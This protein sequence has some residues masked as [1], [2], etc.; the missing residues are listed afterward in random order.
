MNKIILIWAIFILAV[1]LDCG[2]TFYGV[3]FGQGMEWN[4]LAA[5]FLH[6]EL[7][8]WE[9][10]FIWSSFCVCLIL[11]A[12]F[13]IDRLFNHVRNLPDKDPIDAWIANRM[14][15]SNF[16]ILASIVKFYGAYTWIS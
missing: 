5:T 12:I 11:G 14:T 16:I 4:I 15:L 6:P 1:L 9:S 2:I 8:F 3:Y 10:L 7:P 13:F